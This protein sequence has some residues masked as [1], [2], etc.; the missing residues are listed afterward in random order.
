MK[1]RKLAAAWLMAAVLCLAACSAA[2]QN[3]LENADETPVVEVSVT[4]GGEVTTTSVDETVEETTESEEQR[5]AEGWEQELQNL[6][7]RVAENQERYAPKTQTLPS[8][9]EIQRTPQDAIVYNTT[10]LHADERGC[11]ACH[12]DLAE[13]L[14]NF[15]E[16]S[17]VNFFRHFEFSNDYGIE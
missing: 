4:E 15:E 8:G 11:A 17:S 5:T 14:E 7:A 2:E 9:V 1:T 16:F 12:T 10:I 6:Y 3:S 13:T